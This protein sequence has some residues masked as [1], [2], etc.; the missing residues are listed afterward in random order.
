[1]VF[2]VTV[3]EVFDRRRFSPLPLFVGRI[4]AAIY[5]PAQLLGLSPGCRGR[6]CRIFADRVSTLDAFDS[7]VD[8]EGSDARRVLLGCGEYA[9]PKSSGLRIIVPSGDRATGWRW[10]GVDQVA[11]Q[12]FRHAAPR[13]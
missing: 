2:D 8:E 7:I 12:F 13:Q 10:N 6:P 1:M 4:F 11:R 3:D 5:A 9:N